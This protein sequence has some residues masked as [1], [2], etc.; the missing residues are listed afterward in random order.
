[1]TTLIA[2]TSHDHR[3]FAALHIA[4]DSRISWGSSRRRW[5]AGRKIFCS[6][7][8]PDVWAYSGDVLFPALVLSQ[9]MSVADTGLLFTNEDS[10]AVRHD[11]VFNALKASF[12][13]RH[14]TPDQD[15]TI[16]HASRDGENVVAKPKLWKTCYSKNAKTWDDGEMEIANIGIVAVVGTGSKALKE[17]AARWKASSIGNTSRSI[18][19]AFC[20]AIESGADPL[21]GGAPQLGSIYPKG[22]AVT[23]GVIY[24]NKPHIHGLPI[25]LTPSMGDIQWFDKLFQRIDPHTMS[26]IKGAARHATPIGL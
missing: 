6:K 14:N 24:D 4:S 7:T 16:L 13:R 18:Y 25:Q 8:T 22:H 10:A 26:V 15:F 2:W 19:S 11:A 9:I 3:K 17:E 5:D 21:S 1:M 20:K 23:S 12:E